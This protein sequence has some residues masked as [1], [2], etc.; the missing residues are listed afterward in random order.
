MV[1]KEPGIYATGGLH[2]P[3]L[4]RGVSEVGNSEGVRS[5]IAIA[6]RYVVIIGNTPL[7]VVG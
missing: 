6:T 1:G 7:G 2:G 4:E 3:R 5:Y